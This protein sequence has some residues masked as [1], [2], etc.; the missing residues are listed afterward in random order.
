MSRDFRIEIKSHSLEELEKSLARSGR[1]LSAEKL[2][3][4]P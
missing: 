1:M 3:R 2:P 4:L